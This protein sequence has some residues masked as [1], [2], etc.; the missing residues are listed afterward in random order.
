MKRA[1]TAWNRFWFS[2]VPTST[3]AA[4]RIGVG[5]LALLSAVTL[6]HDLEPFYGG[7]GL[8][9]SGARV[10]VAVLALSAACL[11]VGVCARVAALA[12][13]LCLGELAGVNPFIFNS[14]DTLLRCLVLVLVVAPAGAGLSIASRRRNGSAWRFPLR[15][16]WPLRLIQIQ[17]AVMYLAAVAHKLQGVTWR[18]GTA[19]SYPI[20]IPDMARFPV[21]HALADSAIA[22]HVFTWGTLAIE[23][24]IPV[25]V[26]SR[27]A[28]PWVLGLGIGLHLGIDYSL[29]AGLF[30]WVV[31]VGYLAFVPPEAMTRGLERLRAFAGSL[32]AQPRRVLPATG[33]SVS[34][35]TPRR[36][37]K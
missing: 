9:A 35:S 17:I 19:A 20:R 26:W 1:A 32:R 16:V 24:A 13:F 22:A 2:P 28:R 34:S 14:G 25:L 5:V 30:S 18:D 4:F 33:P 23:G 8:D 7:T 29:R 27:R 15:P 3:L 21:P 12:V 6:W 31:L 37:A 10:L 11:I 36:G